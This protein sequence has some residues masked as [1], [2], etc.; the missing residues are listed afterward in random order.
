MRRDQAG[1]DGALAGRLVV[2]VDGAD[3]EQGDVGVAARGVARRRLDQVRQDR[4]PHAVQVRRDRILQHQPLV[5]AA[6][7]GRDRLLGEGPGDGLGVAQGRQG[8]TGGAHARLARAQHA[9]RLGRKRGQ[10]RLGQGREAVDAR[11]LFDQV[12]GTLHVAAPRRRRHRPGRAAHDGEAQGEQDLEDPVLAQDHA[13]Q[14]LH[15]GR[16]EGER[17]GR[18]RGLA[19]DHDLGRLA[20]AQV[21]DQP[22]RQL[23]PRDHRSRID[24]AREAILGVGVDAQGASGLGR[25]DGV[26]PGA[27]DED[28]DRLVRTAGGLPAHDAAQADR[29]LARRVGD[30]AVGR[31]RGVRLAVQGD[32]VL[33][34]ALGA[35]AAAHDDL[36]ARQLGQ[37]IDVQRPRAVVGN[38]V[39]DVDE[40]VDGAQADGGQTMLQPVRRWTVLHAADH[41]SGEDRAQIGVV[42]PHRHRRGEGPGHGDDLRRRQLA[43]TGGGQVAGDARHAQ[44][45]GPVR[46]HLEVDHR[47]GAEDARRRG[48]DLQ[49]ARQFQDAV[50]VVGQL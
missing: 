10:G 3:L 18:G 23:Q 22:R 37:V 2:Q 46:G 4:G 6:E 45:V 5:P 17:G 1:D 40:A 20:A 13:R 27:L 11:H 16:V 44:P 33:G 28:V 42:D 9:A 48:P 38:Q 14:A 7:Q 39:G 50:G 35:P 8:A 31:R 21:E 32:Q 34:R 41:P 30:D 49:I 24:A 25:G 19:R 15:I 36:P 47:L 29:P 26:E 12:G 43:Q